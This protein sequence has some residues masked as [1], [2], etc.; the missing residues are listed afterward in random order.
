MQ[1]I[2]GG[3]YQGKLDFVRTSHPGLSETQCSPDQPQLDLSTD[4]IIGLHLWVLAQL[5]AGRDPLQE[6][7][8]VR[9]ELQG[10]IVISDDISCGVVPIDPELRRWRETTGRVL[11]WVSQWS[12]QVNR[13]FC[14]IASRI[15]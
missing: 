7:E 13:L 5:R 12:E 10:K 6:L 9:D 1:L 4:V 14:G 8:A 2:I 15:K 3:A 11:A